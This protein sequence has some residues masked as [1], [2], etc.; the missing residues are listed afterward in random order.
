MVT[1]FF[2]EKAPDFKDALSQLKEKII[3]DSRILV[4]I[5]LGGTIL[6]RGISTETKDIERQESFK[7]R[8]KKCYLRPG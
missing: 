6:F 5:D 2:L 3:R 4:L 8:K 7:C 1:R